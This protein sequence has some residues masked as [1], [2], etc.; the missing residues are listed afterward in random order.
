[1][2]TKTYSSHSLSVEQIYLISKLRSSGVSR[3]QAI[4]AWNVMDRVDREE[5]ER[6]RSSAPGINEPHTMPNIVP[7]SEIAAKL[8]SLATNIDLT[9]EV[10]NHRAGLTDNSQSSHDS[11]SEFCQQLSPSVVLDTMDT[12]D[13]E[14]VFLEYKTRNE[15]EVVDEI[16]TFVMIHNIKQQ[17]IADMSGI[18][19]GYISKFFRGEGSEMSDRSKNQII[20]WYLKYRDSPEKIFEFVSKDRE[21]TPTTPRAITFGLPSSSIR[22]PSLTVTP[23]NVPIQSQSLTVSRLL[24]NLS[25]QSRFSYPSGVPSSGYLGGNLR[26]Q[27]FIFRKQQIE[28]LEKYFQ[29]NEYPDQYTKQLIVDELN[30][31][32]EDTN[33]RPLSE[34]DKVSYPVVST[35]FNNK[36]KERSKLNPQSSPS[37]GKGRPPR[38]EYYQSGDESRSQEESGLKRPRSESPTEPDAIVS[39]LDFDDLVFEGDRGISHIK[40]EGSRNRVSFENNHGLVDHVHVFDYDESDFE[41]F[42][43]PKP[44]LSF[45][46]CSKTY[47]RHP[48]QLTISSDA[49]ESDGNQA[50]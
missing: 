33:G 48:Q 2:N 40:V 30:S 24:P 22:T 10:S 11:E 32:S 7:A 3:D 6:Q 9:H 12:R 23:I 49:L 26:R 18:S 36:R 28:I 35:W 29:Q 39:N 42:M 37:R 4:E 16:K 31:I 45:K 34:R 1:M 50:D 21:S 14:T 17:K 44:D 41:R 5:K 8:R 13:P 47:S 46:D 25:P 15:S 43:H 19:Q 20:R 38:S 27:R